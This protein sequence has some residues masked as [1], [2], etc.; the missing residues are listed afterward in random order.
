MKILINILFLIFSVISVKAQCSDLL[1]KIN[2]NGKLEKYSKS[3]S[4]QGTVT[5]QVIDYDCSG[6]VVV[7]VKNTGKVEKYSISGSYQ[8]LITSDG[9]KVKVSGDIILVTKKNGKVEKYT[10]SGSYKGSI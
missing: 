2:S 4:Y 9:V 10:F 6:K 1:F 7:V 8:G 3:N 5:T